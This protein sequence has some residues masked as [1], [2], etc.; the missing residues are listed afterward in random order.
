[1]S[2]YRATD[3][4]LDREIDTLER[5]GRVRLRRAAAEL[6]EV[7]KDLRE[8]RKEKARRAARAAEMVS[9]E[10]P[11]SAESPASES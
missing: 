9:S 1:M 8:L 4:Q 7:D 2:R 11:V 6:N 3:E 10:T 5:I